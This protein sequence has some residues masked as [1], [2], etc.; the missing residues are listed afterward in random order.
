MRDNAGMALVVRIDRWEYIGMFVGLKGPLSAGAYGCMFDAWR[1]PDGSLRHEPPS[2]PSATTGPLNRPSPVK[3]NIP[4]ADP[5]AAEIELMGTPTY[6]D[7]IIHHPA[8]DRFPPRPWR[9][10]PFGCSHRRCAGT[11]FRA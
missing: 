9:G 3:L 10:N 4:V 5:G 6:L 7:F 8:F 1:H 11:A 2:L